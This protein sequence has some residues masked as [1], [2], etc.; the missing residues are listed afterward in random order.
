PNFYKTKSDAQD[1][2]EAI[3]PTSMQYHPDDVRPHLTPDQYYLY[4][5]IWNRFVASQMMPAV[6][7]DTSVDITAKDYIFRAKGSVP[8][9]A[10]WLAVYDQTTGEA[11]ESER[12][13]KAA[14]NPTVAQ[15]A[16][17]DDDASSGLLPAMVEGQ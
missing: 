13:E 4:R 14:P 8:K 17:T 7:D 3:R 6:F 11:E 5:L 2:H 9:F 10:G 16:E 1:A 12:T 15:S